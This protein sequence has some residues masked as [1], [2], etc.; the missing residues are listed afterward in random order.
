MTTQLT[1]LRSRVLSRTR[2]LMF[3]TVLM[4]VA[5]CDYAGPSPT[6]PSLSEGVTPPASAGATRSPVVAT[7]PPSLA[8]QPTIDPAWVTRAALWC[9]EGPTFPPEALLSLGAEFGIDGAA[10]ALRDTILHSSSPEAPLPAN[11]WRRVWDAADQ[12]LFIAPGAKLPWAQILVV[13]STSGWVPR[14]YGECQMQVAFPAGL[15][16]ADWS[17]DPAFPPPDA[18]TTDLHLLA[19]ETACASGRSPQGRIAS[20]LVLDGLQGIT[21]V[22]SVRSLPGPQDCVGNPPVRV[23]VH[24]PSALGTRS[25]LDGGAFPARPVWPWSSGSTGG[26]SAICRSA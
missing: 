7:P 12:V 13:P 21:V 15:G 3:A 9:G 19:V 11:G 14:T 5:A 1:V 16:R 23:L 6:A 17:V 18:T 26:A 8:P 24:L 22:I 10:D 25:L 20:P 4:G 2:R